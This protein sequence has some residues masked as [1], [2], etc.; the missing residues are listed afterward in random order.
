MTD[1]IERCSN[2]GE[3]FPIRG[4]ASVAAFIAHIKMHEREL[5]QEI[6]EA[7][8][9][10]YA[11]IHNPVQ[12]DDCPWQVVDRWDDDPVMGPCWSARDAAVVAWALEHRRE[13]VEQ[14]SDLRELV[15]RCVDT[16]I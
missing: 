16:T 15:D 10:R 11:P 7:G 5:V 1:K 9:P 6:A 14:H 2:C 4:S 8:G 13:L 3:E 12:S